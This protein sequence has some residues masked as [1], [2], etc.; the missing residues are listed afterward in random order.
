MTVDLSKAKPGMIAK[1][2]CGGQAVIEEVNRYQDYASY[3]S[4]KGEDYCQDYKNDGYRRFSG[5]VSLFD[6]IALEEPP[7]DWANV[8]PGDRFKHVRYDMLCEFIG[9]NSR[10]CYVLTV[11]WLGSNYYAGWEHPEQDFTPYLDDL[12]NEND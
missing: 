2:R 10:G 11:P 1:F 6:I 5:S 7:S 8:K 4:F 3:I 12:V 9:K